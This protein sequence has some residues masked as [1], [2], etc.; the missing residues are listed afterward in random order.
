MEKTIWTPSLYGRCDFGIY[1]DRNFAKEMVKSKVPIK[2]QNRM[3]ELANEELKR[4]GINWLNPYTFQKDS[5]FITQFYIGQ[6]GVWLSTDHLTIENL[7]K[8]K[9]SSKLIEYNS[10][11]T[12]TSKQA[13]ILML[14]FDTWVRYA[15]A[16][17]NV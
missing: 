10:H 2:K 5:C 17:K 6:N 11:N 15:D 7:L 12:D 14:L 13:Y 16:F 8:E 4:F 3:N 1:L 9:E